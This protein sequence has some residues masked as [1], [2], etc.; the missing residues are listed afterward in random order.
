M[1]DD[2]ECKEPYVI[3]FVDRWERQKQRRRQL[4]MHLSRMV[5]ISG[6][7]FVETTRPPWSRIGRNFGK[8]DSAAGIPSNYPILPD[9]R[10]TFC[11]PRPL[12]PVYGTGIFGALARE[13]VSRAMINTCRGA[14]GKHLKDLNVV[15]IVTHPWWPL[16]F[17]KSLGLT[18]DCYD[19]IDKVS[20]PTDLPPDVAGMLRVNDDD[21]TSAAQIVT[22]SSLEL[23][24]R[25]RLLN[26]NSHLLSDGV[27]IDLF[28]DPGVALNI[29]RKLRIPTESKL[30]GY[31]GGV[32]GRL[33]LNILMKIAETRPQWQIV[34][35][36]KIKND[37]LD[38][39]PGIHLIGD[40]TPDQ[41]SSFLG[42][43][44]LC[45]VPHKVMHLER[46]TV[47]PVIM[48][49][50]ASGK[51]VVTT[52]VIP[53]GELYGLVEVAWSAEDFVRAI[54]RALMDTPKRETQRLRYASANSWQRKAKTMWGLIESTQAT[55]LTAD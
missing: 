7:L 8:N 17:Y 12:F 50:L 11:S 13:S 25:K 15:T 20:Q 1:V 29:R 22:C 40:I 9:D 55:K 33:D 49:G 36:G 6:L 28:S 30:I 42:E 2:R 43:M 45:I 41:V 4:A 27:D 24:S 19:C 32:S 54:D 46:R 3:Y 51:P 18:V 16:S 48:D 47:P 5:N 53:S 35:A 39:V 21:L 23:L 31:H 38:G 44:D 26:S 52:P 14:W 10:M 34:I 37:S